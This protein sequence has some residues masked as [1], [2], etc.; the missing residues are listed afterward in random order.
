MPVLADSVQALQANLTAY[1][2]GPPSLRPWPHC[3]GELG[4]QGPHMRKP[5][6][7][8]QEGHLQCVERGGL[9]FSGPQHSASKCPSFQCLVGM[10]ES[11]A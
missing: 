3:L 2:S 9:G 11:T 5:G 6:S 10:V 4:T 8:H 1:A 7:L